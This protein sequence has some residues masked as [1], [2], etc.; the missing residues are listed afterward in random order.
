MTRVK[1]G[2]FIEVSYIGKVASTQVIFDLTDEKLAK[3][4]HIYNPNHIYGPLIICIGEAQI[5]KGIDDN[6]VGKEVG[7]TYRIELNAENA[8][9]K[10]DPKLILSPAK[11]LELE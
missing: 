6:L 10:K 2:D 7:K 8:F 9:G 5:L 11:R 3:E 4:Q 1:K